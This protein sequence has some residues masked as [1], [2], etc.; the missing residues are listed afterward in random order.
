MRS[1]GTLVLIAGLLAGCATPQTQALHQRTPAWAQ[2]AHQIQSVPFY[3][4]ESDQC[5][6]AT[7]AMALA[8]A[9][10][11]ARPED[12]RD[13][14][15]V[16]GRTGT[17]APEMLVAARRRGR[18]AVQLPPSL[19]AVLQEID[20]GH[21]VIV[22]QNLGLWFFPVW[23]YALVIGYD[24][25]QD[26]LVLHSG[27]QPRQVMGLELFERTWARSGYW[28]MVA[29]DPRSLPVS[30]ASEDLLAA[31]VALERSDASAARQAYRALTQREPENYGAWMG[32]GNSAYAQG[33][34]PAA[35]AAFAAASA[36][37]PG[38]GD[39]WNNLAMGHLAAGQL[40]QA[41]AA[42]EHAVGLG[43]EHLWQYRQTAAQI[44]Q[45]RDQARQGR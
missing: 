33:D 12:L 17:L 31:A 20:A 3:L 38:Q 19:E 14:V 41:Q 37:S 28:A 23:H 22:L 9:G 7:L 43:G 1:L 40:A 25:D 2:R 42:I 16:P 18:L 4:Q 29:V 39:A 24:L 8:A 35:I 15:F 44:E 36:L 21:P 45:A 11:P 13:L 34:A 6:P 10:A 27:P 5:G 26:Q 32:L 30:V